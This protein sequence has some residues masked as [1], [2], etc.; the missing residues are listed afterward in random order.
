ML[1]K[2][3]ERNDMAHVTTVARRP[4]VIAASLVGLSPV[5]RGMTMKATAAMMYVRRDGDGAA[6]RREGVAR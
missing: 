6:T 3:R 1:G 2:R 5:R 4:R